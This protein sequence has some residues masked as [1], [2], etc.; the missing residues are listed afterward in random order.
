M[1]DEVEALI[2]KRQWNRSFFGRVLGLFGLQR[3]FARLVA[4]LRA[5]GV[6][7]GI[8]EEQVEESL[9]VARRAQR[10]A[11]M[12]ARYEDVRA[13]LNS[14]RWLHRWVALLM[15]LLLVLHIVYALFYGTISFE[16]AG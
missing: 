14:W 3:D 13:L 11:L 7:E 5:E 16:A 10:T 12:A 2:E 9:Q 6:R 4:R 15:V 1:R 8:D